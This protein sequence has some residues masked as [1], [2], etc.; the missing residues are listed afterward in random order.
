MTLR[1]FSLGTEEYADLQWFEPVD[2]EVVNFELFFEASEPHSRATDWF[3]IRVATPK[4]LATYPVNPDGMIAAGK[5]LIIPRYDYWTI[6]QWV[7]NM[8]SRCE[9]DTRDETI[10]ELRTIFNWGS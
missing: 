7:E 3:S 8:V 10:A 9:R 5:M 4:G 6:R 2:P 1:A